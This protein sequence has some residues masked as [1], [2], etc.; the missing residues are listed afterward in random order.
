MAEDTSKDPKK[1]PKLEVQSDPN[2]V[3]V[4]E[5]SQKPDPRLRSIELKAD[6]KLRSEIKK[7]KKEE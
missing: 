3:S 5:L 2:I 4:Q 1:V 7:A 6:P